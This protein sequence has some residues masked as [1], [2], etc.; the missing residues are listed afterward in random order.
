M[1]FETSPTMSHI[2]CKL[3]VYYPMIHVSYLNLPVLPGNMMNEEG[4]VIISEDEY[5]EIKRIKDLKAI[6]R[7]DFEEL[8]QLKTEVQYC[9]K[10][11]DQCRQRL[12]QGE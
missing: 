4:D 12:I 11:V 10:L 6:Y 5:L 7:T 3:P 9:Q 1:Y 8:K 2:T